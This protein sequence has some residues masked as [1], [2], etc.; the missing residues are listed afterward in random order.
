MAKNWWN[1]SL[2]IE[3]AL[4]R[5][6][7]VDVEIEADL[8][9]VGRNDAGENAR[10]AREVTELCDDM[11]APPITKFKINGVDPSHVY[12]RSDGSGSKI[13]RFGK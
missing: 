6:A 3:D 12:E 13:W 4:G 11:T 10:I 9:L 1:F 5:T 7:D 8:R 2:N